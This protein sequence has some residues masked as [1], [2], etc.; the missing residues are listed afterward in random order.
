MELESTLELGSGLLQSHAN[1]LSDALVDKGEFLWS[2]GSTVFLHQ[3]KDRIVH[4]CVNETIRTYCITQAGM[5]S[6]WVCV[7]SSLR[8]A[9][10]LEQLSAVSVYRCTALEI[11][12]VAR[13]SFKT[14]LKGLKV[15]SI[16][17]SSI[18]LLVHGATRMLL[19]TLGKAALP[20]LAKIGQAADLIC[21]DSKVFDATWELDCVWSMASGS[22]LA[23]DWVRSG[24]GSTSATLSVG[25]SLGSGTLSVYTWQL[26]LG[27]QPPEAWEHSVIEECLL[28]SKLMSLH[29]AEGAW[30]LCCSRYT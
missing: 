29:A 20:K 22:I 15:I 3:D 16:S 5:G 24:D 4:Q 19:C 2:D 18:L 27:G 9:S 17:P 11:S 6:R 12:H 25:A 13:I 28:G 26:A 14:T 7:V 23:A 10:R 21:D 1:L 8:T 30:V